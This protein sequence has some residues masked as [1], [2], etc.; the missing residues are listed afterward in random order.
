MNHYHRRDSSLL[1]PWNNQPPSLPEV[2]RYRT[3]LGGLTHLEL[4]FSC[5]EVQ[6]PPPASYPSGTRL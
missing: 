1:N 4:V 3:T 6:R 2:R 5:S